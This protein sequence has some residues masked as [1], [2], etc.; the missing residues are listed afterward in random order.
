MKS[1]FLCLRWDGILSKA[2]QQSG[3]A[4]LPCAGGIMAVFGSCKAVASGKC[5]GPFLSVEHVNVM[6]LQI[7]QQQVMHSHL[8][9]NPPNSAKW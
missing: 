2:W 1:L 3:I 5:Q 8:L 7:R 6:W 4:I 9:P